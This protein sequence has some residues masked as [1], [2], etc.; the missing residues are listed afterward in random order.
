MKDAI[1]RFT[2]DSATEFL[3]G[4]DVHS[5]DAE[6]PFPPWSVRST[7][8]SESDHPADR[9][10][11]SFQRAQELVGQRIRFGPLYPLFEPLTNKVANERKA[12]DQF[13]LPIIKTAIK[14]R[15][16]HEG[17][18]PSA[19]STTFLDHLLDSVKGISL[20]RLPSV[21]LT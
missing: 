15:E 7:S 8:A 10:V 4:Q 2:L 5:L 21:N 1:S 20:H 14:R 16:E 9:F 3:F 13:V 19:T 6:L 12:I 11:S 17:G 18:L